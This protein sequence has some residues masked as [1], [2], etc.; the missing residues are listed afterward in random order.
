LLLEWRNIAN[1][2][3]LHHLH[4]HFR[5]SGDCLDGHEVKGSALL[6]TRFINLGSMTNAK[7]NVSQRSE[8]R[9]RNADDWRPLTNTPEI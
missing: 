2:I 8:E 4:L 5:S 3:P 1:V 6:E 7:D 9:Q